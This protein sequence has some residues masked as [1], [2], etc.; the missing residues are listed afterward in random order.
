METVKTTIKVKFSCSTSMFNATF[1]AL[2]KFLIDEGNFILTR[3]VKSKRYI[4]SFE[5][6]DER[7]VIALKN[8]HLPSF[9]FDTIIYAY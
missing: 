7:S 9:K 3:D 8:L 6:E 5:P 2:M 1:D 4:C